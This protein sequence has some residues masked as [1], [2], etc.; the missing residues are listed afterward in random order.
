MY[1][2]PPVTRILRWFTGV[3]LDCS[4]W[5]PHANGEARAIGNFPPTA[6]HC[7]GDG[8]DEFGITTF[9]RC[10]WPWNMQPASCSGESARHARAPLVC[11]PAAGTVGQVP[12]GGRPAIGV[13]SPAEDLS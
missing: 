2:A 7:S 9:T 8:D 3:S 10:L 5:K 1:P 11:R 6:R 12:S 4:S 13:G